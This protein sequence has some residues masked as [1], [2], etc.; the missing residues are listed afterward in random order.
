MTCRS[1]LAAV[2]SLLTGPIVVASSNG[3]PSSI[4]SAIASDS[5]ERYSSFTSS[6]TRNLSPAVQLCPAL[7]NEATRVASTAL[8]RSPSSQITSGPFPPISSRSSFPAA[9]W[10]TVCPVAIEPMKPTACVPGFAA[11][12][13]PTTG[14]GP[15]TMFTTPGGRSAASM[16]SASPTAQIEVVGAGAHTTVFP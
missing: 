15:V 14:P 5:F 16:H 9:R 7:R 12:S 3:S 11:I 1:V 13:S 6:W 2:G 10:A 8:S 4:R